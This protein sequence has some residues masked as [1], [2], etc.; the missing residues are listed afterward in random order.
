MIKYMEEAEKDAA[1]RVADLMAAAARTA[2]KGSK[3]AFGTSRFSRRFR[4]QNDKK[5]LSG[6]ADCEDVNDAAGIPTG[7]FIPW[8]TASPIVLRN[9]QDT[10]VR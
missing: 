1:L 5:I 9:G 8:K 4:R 2:P 3:T 6:D 7:S 10:E